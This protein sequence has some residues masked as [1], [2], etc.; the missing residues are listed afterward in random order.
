MKTWRSAFIQRGQELEAFGFML[1]VC[2]RFQN[3]TNEVETWYALSYRF[4]EDPQVPKRTPCPVMAFRLERK[5]IGLWAKRFN[6]I[7]AFK[8][9]S[10]S[11][12]ANSCFSP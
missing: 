6:N 1:A 4:H 12:R 3:E 2:S 11:Q 5:Q 10:C 7:L 8:D 9:E